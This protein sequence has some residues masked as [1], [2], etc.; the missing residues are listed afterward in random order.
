MAPEHKPFI[1]PVRY[2]KDRAAL[3]HIFRVTCGE[4]LKTEPAWTIS[5]YLWCHP[6]PQLS[7]DT[8]FVL[9]CG[10]GEAVGYVLGTASTEDFAKR[11][12]TEFLPALDQ[13]VLPRPPDLASEG[14]QG[15]AWDSD[16]PGH[17]LNLVYYDYSTMLNLSR[18]QMME[19]WPS[20][21]HI[22]ILPSYQ[23]QGWGRKLIETFLAALASRNL[24]GVHLGMEAGNT[25]SLK[26]YESIGFSRYPFVLDDG[27]SGETGR[28]G[29]GSAGVIYLVKSLES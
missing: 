11:W 7:P 28:T 16:L 6:Y 14:K 29:E 22:D 15:P 26:F 24:K 12:K 1:R 3:D 18:P 8:C 5:S 10:T 17:L 25:G 21:L 4:S 9:D 27:L 2:S 23:R 19:R 20:H 13:E